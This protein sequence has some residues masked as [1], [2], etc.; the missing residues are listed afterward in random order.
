M[1]TTGDVEA[2][3]KVLGDSRQANQSVNDYS[4]STLAAVGAGRAQ[5]EDMSRFATQSAREYLAILQMEPAA[6]AAI[7][8]AYPGITVAQMATLPAIKQVEQAWKD[9]G[10]A[11]N[12]ALSSS[13]NRLAQFEN[14]LP[15]LAEKYDVSFAQMSVAE[16]Q[17]T[18]GAL[19][20]SELVMGAL[21]K[22]LEA[23]RNLSAGLRAAY[24]QALKELTSYLAK[25]AELKALEQAAMAIS[26]LASFNFVGFAEHMAAA[27]AWEALGAGV[28]AAVGAIAGGGQ[29]RGRSSYGGSGSYGSDRSRANSVTGAGQPA[30]GYQAQGGAGGISGALA[31]GAQAAAQPSGGLTVAIMGNEEA[32]QWLATTLNK[33]VTQQGVQLVSSAS[34]RGAPVGH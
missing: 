34:Q 14:M 30:G 7:A 12:Q 24:Q 1:S 26:D 25:E 15:G 10:S 5:G 16:Q 9:Q 32:G 23:H 29:T 22:E 31:P 33:A 20:G 28:S 3:L 13:L 6:L 27:A 21:N 19:Q 17:F 18:L 11:M 2:L 4:K 8:R